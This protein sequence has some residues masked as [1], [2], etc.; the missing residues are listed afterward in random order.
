MKAEEINIL[1]V[2]DAVNLCLWES[3]ICDENDRYIN[4]HIIAKLNDINDECLYINEKNQFA[5]KVETDQFRRIHVIEDKERTSFRVLYI[6]KVNSFVKNIEKYANLVKIVDDSDTY[7][8]EEV[9]K[10]MLGLKDI[11]K[12]HIFNVDYDQIKT[13]M[14][15]EGP[16]KFFPCIFWTEKKAFKKQ[17][18]I[19]RS[20]SFQIELK[21][22]GK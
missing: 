6:D 12:K 3:Y 14:F 8:Y 1:Y 19:S 10:D 9:T 22:E 16:Y 17:S 15:Q 5:I 13:E 4:D 2:S 11:T 18:T 20:E 7:W 21:S